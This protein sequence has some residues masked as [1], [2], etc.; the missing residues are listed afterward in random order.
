[1]APRCIVNQRIRIEIIHFIRV[2]LG[3]VPH[4][5]YHCFLPPPPIHRHGNYCS[6]SMSPQMTRNLGDGITSPLERRLEVVY[7]ISLSSGGV[8][9]SSTSRSSGTCRVS[10]FSWERQELA[11]HTVLHLLHP[12]FR[13]GSAGAAFKHGAV[14]HSFL[15]QPLL[16]LFPS[17]LPVAVRWA[18]C[19]WRRMPSA[20]SH[21][22]S[23]TQC[24][25]K[26]K[27]VPGVYRAGNG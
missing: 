24:F 27:W 6:P 7:G 19:L 15:Y 11:N 14:S 10:A 18:L 13:V 12:S 9:Q 21:S 3:A 5:K 17:S 23:S 4:L 1:M 20:S 26:L 2:S 8:A 22:P 25:L 16:T